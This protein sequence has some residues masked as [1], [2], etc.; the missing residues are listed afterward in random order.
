MRSRP[1]VRGFC[2]LCR[3]P[4]YVFWIGPVEHDKQRAPAYACEDCC[5]FVRAYVDQ[6]NRQ[7]DQRPA[8]P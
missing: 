4:K 1:L 2:L 7:W 5:A 3:H 6:F 8:V